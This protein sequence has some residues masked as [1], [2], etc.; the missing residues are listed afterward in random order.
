MIKQ[1]SFKLVQFLLPIFFGFLWISPVQASDELHICH[2]PHPGQ[3]FNLTMLKPILDLHQKWLDSNPKTQWINMDLCDATLQGLDLSKLDLS[4]INLSGSDLSYSKLQEAN[5]SHSNLVRTY[6]REANLSNANL[7]SANLQTAILESAQLDKAD[8]NRINLSHANLSRASLKGTNLLLA[9]LKNAN[10]SHADLT[11]AD[12]RWTD[13][14]GADLSGANLTDAAMSNANLT[15]A[16]LQGTILTNANLFAADLNR[17]IYEPKL[18]G[19]PDLIAFHTVR[20]FRNIQFQ[21]YNNGR[22]ALTEL[23]GAYQ[24]IGIRSMERIV[25]AII[26]YQEMVSNWHM[27]GWGYVSSIF[28]YVFFYLTCDFG[29]DPGRPLKIFLVAIFVFALLYRYALSKPSKHPAIM[30]IWTP[31]RFY[32]WKKTQEFKK[33]SKKLMR[34]LKTSD[35]F[36]RRKPF[37]YQ[38]RCLRTALFFSALSAFSVVW[39]EVN[40]NNWIYLLQSREFTLKARGWVQMVSGFQALLSAYLIVLW[41]VIYFGR[42]FE[43]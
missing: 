7:Q 5:L 16:N 34:V 22:A 21:D 31:K 6:F 18:A 33:K 20:N 38:L 2:S 4:Y 3:V 30:V 28:N 42:P 35:N 32:H 43:W 19:L 12:L 8:L 13:L 10:L 29:A 15:S 39:R 41:I 9:N 17:A 36:G 27:G 24:S 37:F 23:R 1:G 14:S 40:V 26:K 25:T 11:G